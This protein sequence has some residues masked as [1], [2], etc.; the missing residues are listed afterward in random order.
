MK[1]QLIALNCLVNLH[2]SNVCN[3]PRG[4]IVNMCL[5]LGQF[6]LSDAITHDIMIIKKTIEMTKMRM[7]LRKLKSFL[8]FYW[9]MI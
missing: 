2:F 6:T 7:E 9:I 1:L 4:K 8:L 5:N 3:K